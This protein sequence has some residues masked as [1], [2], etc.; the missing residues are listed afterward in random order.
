MNLK[1]LFNDALPIIKNFAPTIGAAI[2]GPAGAAAGYAIPILANSF[3]ANPGDI[4]QIVSN[5]LQDPNAEEK[6]DKAEHEH[7]DIICAL[8]DSMHGL[9]RAEIN[10]KLEWDQK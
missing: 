4:K 1:E 3:G 8:I 5:I 9:S 2:G 10:L 6:L 7:K